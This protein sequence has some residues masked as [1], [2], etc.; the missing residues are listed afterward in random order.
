MSPQEGG[1]EGLMGP[2]L[3]KAQNDNKFLLLRVFRNFPE[4][5]MAYVEYPDC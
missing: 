5:I 4:K 3:S 2:D 1:I